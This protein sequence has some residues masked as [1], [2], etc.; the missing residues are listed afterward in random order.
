LLPILS[1]LSRRFV[2]RRLFKAVDLDMPIE[3]RGE[4]LARARACVERAGFDPA[5]Y[6]IEDRATDVPYYNY[7]TAEGVERG[8]HRLKIAASPAS[9]EQLPLLPAE[10]LVDGLGRVV[11]VAHTRAAPR[12]SSRRPR[13][14]G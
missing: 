12:R 13:L 10:I 3:E 1:D 14:A 9:R 8:G 2:G 7:Y 5:Y 4:F 6:F 11:R